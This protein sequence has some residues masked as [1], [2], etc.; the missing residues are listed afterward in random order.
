MINTETELSDYI[1]SLEKG[2]FGMDLEADG[3]HRYGDSLCLI[4]AT[5]GGNHQLI[6]PLAFK[7]MESIIDKI[8]TATVWMHGADYDM[9][10]MKKAW[11]TLPKQIFDTQI[12]SRLVGAKKF[13]Y[14]NLVQDF[15][16]VE[17]D[18][19][20]QKADWAKRPLTDVMVEYA[21]NDVIYLQPLAE[22]LVKKLKELGR[23]EWFEESCDDALRKGKERE[24]HRDEPWRIKG[25]GKLSALGLAFLKEIWYWREEEAQEW[26]KPVFM[27]CSNKTLLDWV[28]SLAAGNIPELPKHY[29]NRRVNRFIGAANKARRLPPEM[30]PQKQKVTRVPKDPELEERIEKVLKQKNA[31]AAK[32]DMDSSLLA[33]RMT[34]EE[35]VR[36]QRTFEDSLMKWQ[37]ELL[38]DIF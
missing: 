33:S 38:I 17:L 24:L 30:Y 22:V 28:D 26:D 1:S 36:G 16:G 11:N 13:G 23:Y 6:D 14:A 34:V 3:L 25:S 15:L 27:V 10:L 8:E 29:R 19:A 18:K 9:T 32:L 21:L 2:F 37:Q 7:A 12:A 4:Q 5:D 35:I 31:I 20:S